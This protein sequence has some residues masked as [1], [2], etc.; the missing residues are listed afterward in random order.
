MSCGCVARA[1]LDCSFRIA[2]TT[3]DTQELSAGRKNRQT[4]LKSVRRALGAQVSV[5]RLERGN[6]LQFH[7]Q[8]LRLETR[9]MRP[10][11]RM[12]SRSIPSVS[13]NVALSDA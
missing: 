5:G 11:V 8:E 1:A 2:C 9:W 6:R 4:N 12:N 10:A 3:K 7:Q 13:A